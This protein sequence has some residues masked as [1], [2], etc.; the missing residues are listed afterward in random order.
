MKRLIFCLCFLICGCGKSSQSF[1]AASPLSQE[2]ADQIL[3]EQVLRVTPGQP[4]IPALAAYRHQSGMLIAGSAVSSPIPGEWS[5]VVDKS[6]FLYWIDPLTTA[7]LGHSTTVIFIDQNGQITTIP[8]QFYPQVNGVPQ[9]VDPTN[10]VYPSAS[11]FTT[12]QAVPPGRIAIQQTSTSLDTDIGGL[13]VAGDSRG[14]FLAEES[15]AREAFGAMGGLPSELDKLSVEDIPVPTKDELAKSLK[16]ASQGLGSEDKFYLHVAAHGTPTHLVLGDSGAGK[17][18]TTVTWA[19]LCG[20]LSENVSAGNVNI[21]VT[22]CYSGF[23]LDQL[24]RWEQ[25]WKARVQVITTGFTPSLGNFEGDGPINGKCAVDDLLERLD[26]ATLEGRL[27]LEALEAA[28]AEVEA[29]REEI[30]EK[31]C[32][33]AVQFEQ[34]NP[35]KT[36]AKIPTSSSVDPVAVGGFDSR[37]D[38]APPP[39]EPDEDGDG[40]PDSEDNCPKHS[41][42]MQKD[43]DADGVGDLCDPDYEFSREVVY[44]G[45]A[46]RGDAEMVTAQIIEGGTVSVENGQISATLS[47]NQAQGTTG[48]LTLNGELRN[49]RSGNT[50]SAAL[51]GTYTPEGGE[52][53]PVILF[54]EITLYGGKANRAVFKGGGEI[55]IDFVDICFHSV[56]CPEDPTPPADEK[57]DRQVYITSGS[58][59]KMVGLS[60]D[61]PAEGQVEPATEVTNLSNP[62]QPGLDSARNEIYVPNFGNNSISVY[63]PANTADGP[64]GPAR[65]LINVPSGPTVCLYDEVNDRLYVSGNNA[66]GIISIY[67]NAHTLTSNSPPS[68]NIFG[69]VNLPVGLALDPLND[70]LFVGV[71]DGTIKVF[72]S[73]STVDGLESLAVDRE[74]TSSGHLGSGIRCLYFNRTRQRLLAVDAVF[75]NVAGFNT[76]GSLT[77]DRTPDLIIGG[78]SNGF[79]IWEDEVNE[80]IY[81]AQITD[82]SVA[83]LP[84]S[85][86]GPVRILSGLTGATGV[87]GDPNR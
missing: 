73:A 48:T 39:Q 85:G 45:L 50:V 9:V 5:Q 40:I 70:Q 18:P 6:G 84:S 41:N 72:D 23:L 56:L 82:G 33:L 62:Q 64:S 58:G 61:S 69:F 44:G 24:P 78:L 37:N 3:L 54:L 34:D 65:L 60:P 43:E 79:G 76:P 2:A 1:N 55:G 77:G 53:I 46:P 83:I 47:L 87:T 38:P 51:E 67:D 7:R 19:E 31:V 4:V 25:E 28:F 63:S 27:A 81:V 21:V 68:R 8:S 15:L 22:S 80:L 26:A 57:L 75:N 86:V 74:F 20:L 42:P 11:Q 32:D 16:E 35:R 30:V 14:D 49:D 66:G 52:P 17:T 71:T 36:A 10:L 12:R 29:T 59:N 13:F